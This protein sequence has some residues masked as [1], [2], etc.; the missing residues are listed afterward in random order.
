MHEKYKYM[1]L[2]YIYNKLDLKQIE[3]S[4]EQQGINFVDDEID[5]LYTNISKY[6]S[7]VNEVDE[8]R[9]SKELTEK[10]N[11]YFSQSIEKLSEK[12]L[13]DEVFEFLEASY[14]TMLFPNIKEK[15]CFYGPL[16]YKYAAPRDCVVLGLNYC[17][18]DIS[19]DNFD[20][21]YSRRQSFICNVLNYIQENLADKAG[22]NVAVL[23]YNEFS[24]KKIK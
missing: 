24:K 3:T 18:F 14:K 10:Y 1:F 12:E 16:N 22:I 4:L 17:E 13:E 19:E 11:Y 2:K 7:L 5:G 20:E 23:Q 6:F 15:I 8:S 9:L 21:L